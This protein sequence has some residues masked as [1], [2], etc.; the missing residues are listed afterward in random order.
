MMMKEE[1]WGKAGGNAMM[2]LLLLELYNTLSDH[3][4]PGT[5][6]WLWPVACGAPHMRY[7]LDMYPRFRASVSTWQGVLASGPRG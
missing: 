5:R 7:V 3:R 2:R 4:D 1:K 6:L